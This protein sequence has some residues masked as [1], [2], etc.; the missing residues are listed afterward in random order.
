[1]KKNL[2]LQPVL[3]SSSLSFAQKGNQVLLQSTT[4]EEKE[5]AVY[6]VEYAADAK[7]GRRSLAP[8]TPHYI[9]NNKSWKKHHN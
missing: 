7:H 1:M 4:T 6:E 2:L 8:G 3:A 9:G 5:F